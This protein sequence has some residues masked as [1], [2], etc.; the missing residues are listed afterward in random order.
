MCLSFVYFIF[1]QE[2]YD[3]CEELVLNTILYLFAVCANVWVQ[4]CS[5]G[6]IA[7]TICLLFYYNVDV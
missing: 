2:I 6:N 7:K 3:G 1:V 4:Y 5:L